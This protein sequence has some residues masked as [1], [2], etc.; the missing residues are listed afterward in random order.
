MAFVD[1]DFAMQLF[2]A[3]ESQE[4]P[5]HSDAAQIYASEFKLESNAICFGY[6]KDMTPLSE[7]LYEVVDI[8]TLAATC[9][10]FLVLTEKSWKDSVSS[11][12]SIH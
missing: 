7:S 6:R 8:R 11:F 9:D 4:L 10:I 1:Q 12:I 2:T 3:D 5:G